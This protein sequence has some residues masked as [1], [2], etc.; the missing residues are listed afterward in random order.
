MLKNQTVLGRAVKVV[1]AMGVAL[2]GSLENNFFRKVL[3]TGLGGHG[4]WLCSLWTLGEMFSFFM[5]GTKLSVNPLI[6]FTRS[7]HAIV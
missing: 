5:S 7:S 4:F 3:P 6:R 1:L 2:D